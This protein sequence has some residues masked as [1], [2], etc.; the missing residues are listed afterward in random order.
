[1]ISFFHDQFADRTFVRE[2]SFFGKGL[3]LCVA[4]VTMGDPVSPLLLRVLEKL[5]KAEKMIK[6]L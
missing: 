1:M 2:K 3:C 6:V 5:V 4:R